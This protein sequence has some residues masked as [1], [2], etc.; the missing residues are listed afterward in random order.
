MLKTLSTLLTIALLLPSSASAAAADD[1]FK[2][3]TIRVVVGFSAGGG[4]DTYARAIARHMSRHIPG[5]PPIIVENMTGAGSLISAN[6]MFKV[7]KPDG[8]TIGHFIGGLFLGQVLGQPGVEFDGRKFEFI[9]APIT[10]HVVCALTKASG[11]TSVEKWMASKTPVKMGGIAPGTSTPDNA[12]RILKAALGLPIQLVTGYKGTADVR[13]AAESGEVAGGCW[14]WDS[15]KT[16]WRKAI[17]SGDA[18][19]VLQANRK[20]HPE[21]PQIPQAIK[22]AKTEDA[23]RIIDVGIHAD[24]DIVRTYTLPPGTPRDRVQTLRK[25]FDDTLKDAEFLADAK[26][27]N[28]SVVP[29]SVEE[30]ERDINALFKLDPGLVAKL[31]DLLYN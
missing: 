6:H 19:V 2:G 23:R 18:V 3:K 31:K 13:L 27:S 21:L 14:G 29:V 30:I 11:I 12:T 9:G 28:L 26:K 25:A 10:D 22:L 7:A 5:Q 1:F 17:E 8:L 4:F 20:N 24:S 16:T 15:V